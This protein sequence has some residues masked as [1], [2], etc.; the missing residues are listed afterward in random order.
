MVKVIGFRCPDSLV[1]EIEQQQQLT[2]KDKTA[3]VIEM[4]R[5]LPSVDVESRK[6]FPPV[7][8]TYIIWAQ[9]K[10]LYV[11]HTDNLHDCFRDHPRLVEF[12][13]DNARIAWFDTGGTEK[14][15]IDDKVVELFGLG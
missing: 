6:S 12:L 4:I 7:E 5:G 14:L 1:A 2:G 3:I 11:G 13:N 8:A 15:Q 9:S 10:I